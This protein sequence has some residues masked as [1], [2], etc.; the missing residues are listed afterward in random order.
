MTFKHIPERVEIP[1]GWGRTL[2]NSVGS[3]ESRYAINGVAIEALPSGLWAVSTDTASLA[4][5]QVGEKP[6]RLR[7]RESVI[8]TVSAFRAR[9]AEPR[10]RGWGSYNG[11][12]DL[13]NLRPAETVEGIFPKWE[14][15]LPSL[16]DA[17]EWPVQFSLRESESLLNTGP[18]L[19]TTGPHPWCLSLRRLER[20]APLLQHVKRL[21]F[22]KAIPALGTYQIA[23]AFPPS[24]KLGVMPVRQ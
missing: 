24:G 3:H 1:A 17:K 22:R 23:V 13:T 6:K 4:A 14:D 2:L 5:V 21:D 20:F 7:E 9:L 12:L 10:G 15:A 11:F 8:L 19:E 16:D 18:L